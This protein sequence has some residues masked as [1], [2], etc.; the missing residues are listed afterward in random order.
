MTMK[1]ILAGVLA[2]ASALTISMTA[3]AAPEAPDKTKPITKA[4]ETEYEAGVSMMTAELDVEL[5]AQMKAFINPYGAEVA[6]TDEATPTK[7]S[8]GVLSWYYEVVNNTKDFGIII[9]IKDGMATATTG[10]TITDT[11]KADGGAANTKAACVALLSAKDI[12]T[13]KAVALADGTQITNTA[14][15][16][17]QAGGKFVFSGTKTT[18]AKFAYAPKADTDPGKVYIAFNGA[19][20]LKNTVSG[21][22]TP[23]EWTED[24][25]VTC[26]YILKINPAK[27]TAAAALA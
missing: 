3:F 14:E 16:T 8:T 24:D 9:D 19:I 12:A 21:A 10:I 15:T 23:V 11:P 27:G 5:P 22:T 4:G 20:T 18:L 6:V 13:L 17:A 7:A 26:T 2:A 25:S 1:K